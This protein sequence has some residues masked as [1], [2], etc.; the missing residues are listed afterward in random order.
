[1]PR[2]ESIG[3]KKPDLPAP[4]VLA[5]GECALERI[6]VRGKITQRF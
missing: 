2:K 4:T 3:R 5:E 6:T 1:M